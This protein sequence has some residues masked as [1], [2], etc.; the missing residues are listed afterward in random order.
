MSVADQYFGRLG[1][2]YDIKKHGPMVTLTLGGRVEGIPAR[3]AIGGSQGFRRP[4]YT[5]SVEPGVIVASHQWQFALTTP[6]AVLRDRVRSVTDIE[7]STPGNI[8]HGDA[9]F[10]DF[11]VIGTLVY[12]F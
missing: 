5:L 6:V 4:G 10:A 12:R 1:L 2:G 8:V 11:S 3:D 9:A 7:N